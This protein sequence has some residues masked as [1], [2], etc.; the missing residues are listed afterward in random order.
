[1]TKRTFNSGAITLVNADSLEY[2]KTIPD[3]SI[4]L[5]ATDPPYFQVKKMHGITSGITLLS[6]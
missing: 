3:N 4:D 6:F 5:V 2:L 1:M